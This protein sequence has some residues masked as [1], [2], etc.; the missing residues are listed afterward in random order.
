[1]ISH[2]IQLVIDFISGHPG[3]AIFIVFA[4]SMG[5]ALFIIGLFVPS[6]V[7]LVSAGT[8]VGMGQL[9]FLPIYLSATLGAVVGD[10]VSYWI[11]HLGKDWIRDVWPFSRYTALVVKGEAFF[12]RHGAKSVFVG[13]FIPG[14]KAVVPGIAGMM[15]MSATRFSIINVVSALVWTAAHLLP[16]IGLGRGLDVASSANPRLV[17]VLAVIVF[18]IVA[19]WY[20][21]RL[22]L[23]FVLPH[24][25]KLRVAAIIWLNGRPMAATRLAIRLLANEEGILVPLSWALVALVAT[26]GLMAL[27][28]N[29]LFDPALSVSDNA[30]R[31][32]IQNF[33][34]APADEA[35]VVITM[36]GD[37][38]VVA[39]LAGTFILWLLALQRFRLAAAS[40]IAFVAAALFAPTARF[41][42]DQAQGAPFFA[43]GGTTSFPS[44]HATVAAVVYGVIALVLAHDLSARWRTVLYAST[45]TV[46]A[47]IGF[48]RL[49]LLVHWPSEVAA[50]L[51]FGGTV[52]SVV[53]FLIHGRPM[54]LG[55]RWLA[56]VLCVAFLAVYPAHVLRGFDRSVTA[57]APVPEWITVTRARW[58]AE[59]WKVL[60]AAR[61]LLDGA[62]GEP[63]VVQTDMALD[64]IDAD[65]TGAGWRKIKPKRL[66]ALL[67]SAIPLPF[68]L[69]ER[70]VLPFYHSGMRPAAEF[71][72]DTGARSRIVL[73]IWKSALR[74]KASG[75]TRPVFL[76]SLAR[77]RLE[78][79][80]FDLSDLRYRPLDAVERSAM[81]DEVVAALN[82]DGKLQ[83]ATPRQGLT[84]LPVH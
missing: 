27:T 5:E 18:L 70:A 24:L 29:A 51:L 32:F 8:L 83:P 11:G 84:L 49:Y 30:I 50:G 36:L 39:T 55:A 38:A 3:L 41:L 46:V 59:G 23:G 68:P 40:A 74:I 2:F 10:A 6:T 28:I 57:Y 22:V 21:T 9:S 13:R 37:R 79:F 73:R 16:G 82:P 25:E 72:K 64:A 33:R 45:A 35:M 26:S 31:G 78:P 4:I 19:A 67:V 80:V 58:L 12:E 63:F 52:V 43:G 61:I 60:P 77:E 54:Q 62:N 15:G 76:V 48:S 7:V 66:E 56:G 20:L 81:A 47:L 1:M 42:L 14:V 75:G 69:D 44:S 53:A 65:L 71:T 34:T 17:A